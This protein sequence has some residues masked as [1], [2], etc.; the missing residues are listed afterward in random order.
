MVI[1][2]KKYGRWRIC[3]DYKPLNVAT[4]ANHYPLPYMD[5]ILDRVAGHEMY[6]LC[7]GYSIYFQ[8]AIAPEDQMKTPL[9]LL[10]IAFATNKCLLD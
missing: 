7:D 5:D 3:V 6:S 4:K 9:S 1:V 2:P 8:I 10:G